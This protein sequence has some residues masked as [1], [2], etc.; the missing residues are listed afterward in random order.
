MTAKWMSARRV[1]RGAAVA[2][3]LTVIAAGTA[4][5]SVAP[6]SVEQIRVPPAA[7][8]YA[9]MR[10]V[11]RLVPRSV[12]PAP[13]STVRAFSRGARR[14]PSGRYSATEAVPRASATAGAV[15]AAASPQVNFNGVSSRDSEVT[16]YNLKFEPPDQGLCS[17]EGF[18]L[19]AVNCRTASTAPRGKTLRGPF[20][21]ND[22]FNVGGKEY[23]SDPRCL[24]DPT[25]TT[26]FA[27]ILFLNDKFTRS[28]LLISPSGTA[29]T[30]CG[31]W[32]EYSIDTTDEGGRGTGA[33]A[34]VTSRGSG[35]DQTN[36]YV[37]A[38]EFSIHGTAV[39]RLGRLWAIDKSELVTGAEAS[40]T[41]CGSVT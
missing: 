29:A 9:G 7:K 26:W 20:N 39:P 16:N 3:A 23:T 33:R 13:S 25:T 22:L 31:L 4:A 18:V 36:L 19:E 34:S 38:D 24:F 15:A 37:T 8:Y 14:L 2:V 28:S 11:A 40:R 32:N 5:P 12:R 35:I 30:R 17:G 6:T 41:S 27:T 21:I 1:V 10:G